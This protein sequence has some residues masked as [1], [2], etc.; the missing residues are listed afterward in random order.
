MRSAAFENETIFL[1]F[2]KTTYLIEEVNCMS[3]SLKLVFPWT[4]T[5]AYF[6]E[7]S[8]TMKNILWD[9]SKIWSF[10]MHLRPKLSHPSSSFFQGWYSQNYLQT[11]CKLFMNFSWIYFEHVMSFLRTCYELA[12]NM[13][14]VTRKLLWAH[15]ELVTSFI[16]TCYALALSM[17]WA[18]YE[19]V[20][21]P[22]KQVTNFQTCCELALSMLWVSYQLVMNLLWTCY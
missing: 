12:L 16:R 20:M 6:Y 8:L 9:C 7:A 21:N 18:L 1:F 5:L 2:H 11:Y 15:F 22:L 13:L 14:L 10:L 4:N 17:L 19:L 3:L